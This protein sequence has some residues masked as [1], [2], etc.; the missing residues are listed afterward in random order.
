MKLTAVDLEAKLKKHYVKNL[1]MFF[2]IIVSAICSNPDFIVV[3]DVLNEKSTDSLIDVINDALADENIQVDFEVT[4]ILPETSLELLK[5]LSDIDSEAVLG[6]PNSRIEKMRKSEIVSLMA[7]VLTDPALFE[8]F[9]LNLPADQE[10]LEMILHD[11]F[12]EELYHDLSSDPIY[13]KRKAYYMMLRNYTLA[14]V[15]LYGAIE[16]ADLADLI[17]SFETDWHKREDYA[18]EGGSYSHT[19]A[20][21]PRYFMSMTLH[22]IC[23]NS[24][25]DVPMTLEGIVMNEC[26]RN[27]FINEQKKLVKHMQAFAQEKNASPEHPAPLDD[28]FMVSWLDQADAP[29]RDLLMAASEKPRYI[30]MREEF[31]KYADS[32]YVEEGP[33]DRKFKNYIR[34]KYRKKLQKFA[35]DNEVS[36]EEIMQEVWEDI[37]FVF[38]DHDEYWD[39]VDI[40]SKIQVVFDTA[41]NYGIDFNDIQE[42]NEFLTYLMPVMNGTRLWANNGYTPDDIVRLTPP[43]GPVHPTVVP[44]SSHAAK[45]LGEG[46]DQLEEMGVHVDL[47][48][49]ASE[50]TTFSYPEGLAGP[51][52][53]KKKKIYPNDPCPCGSGKKYKYCCGKKKD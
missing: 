32:D 31:L 10:D 27:D 6:R 43:S 15:N 16:V 19:V 44:M 39:D 50:V 17:W 23:G 42:A 30:P 45:L 21:C 46:R 49:N 24:F 53:Q 12:C 18:R 51:S 20:F 28:D 36:P 3:E 2:S 25:Q 47:D 37:K 52:F 5:K 8:G 9:C 22:D 1:R 41:D 40:N 14:A 29:Y 11:L 26:F 7:S 38:Q 33:A 35:S 13:R 4:D 48:S 34:R